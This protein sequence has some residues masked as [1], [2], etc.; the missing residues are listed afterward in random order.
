MEPTTLEDGMTRPGN[1]VSRRGFIAAIG[2]A[3]AASAIPTVAGAVAPPDSLAA[4]PAAFREL[5]ERFR[6]S[7]MV[8]IVRLAER[9]RP[10]FES[11]E[12]RGYIGEVDDDVDWGTGLPRK[13]LLPMERLE[14]LCAEHFGI[15]EGR[16]WGDFNS[17]NADRLTSQLILEVSPAKEDVVTE[18]NRGAT[19]PALASWALSQDVLSVAIVRGWRVPD[20][21]RD[22]WTPE[23]SLIAQWAREVLS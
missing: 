12:F 14:D 23:P 15:A 3:A 16:N 19:L 6:P 1:E 20:A 22:E 17:Q 21:A 7:Y 5:V 13:T 2:A 4:W 8:E 10:G 18:T 11:G 9:L